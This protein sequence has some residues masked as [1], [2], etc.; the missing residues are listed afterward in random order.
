MTN[1]VFKFFIR[2]TLIYMYISLPTTKENLIVRMVIVFNYCGKEEY[3]Q[4]LDECPF[5]Y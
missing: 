3:L 5:D 1:F 2:S 4:I